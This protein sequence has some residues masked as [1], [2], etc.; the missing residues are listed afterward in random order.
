MWLHGRLKS[1]PSGGM[2]GMLGE[3]EDHLSVKWPG[4][5]AY[6]LGDMAD[7]LVESP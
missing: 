6:P 1:L 7:V 4:I 3:D 5:K 2:A